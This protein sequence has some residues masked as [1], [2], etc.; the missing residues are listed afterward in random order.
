VPNREFHGQSQ[1]LSSVS[2]EATDQ[3][4]FVRSLLTP[5]SNRLLGAITLFFIGVMSVQFNEVVE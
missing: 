3:L 5:P 1:P 4:D 2:A